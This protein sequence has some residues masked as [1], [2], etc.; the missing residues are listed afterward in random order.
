[1]VTSNLSNIAFHGYT[2]T[3]LQ[4]PHCN[5]TPFIF[6]FW[7]LCG[8]SPNFHIHV[9]VSDWSP[10]CI[11]LQK[12]WQTD[13]GNIEIENWEA[14]HYNYIL[15]IRRLHSFI[16]GNTYTGTRQLYWILTGPSFAVR[17]YNVGYWAYSAFWFL[18]KRTY[19]CKEGYH[20]RSTIEIQRI[21]RVSDS[22]PAFFLLIATTS[23]K[24]FLKVQKL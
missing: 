7:E 19:W 3:G 12:N 16:S 2:F 4:S 1:M 22:Y 6:L 20:L 5:K 11:W 13:P 18:R 23:N 21:L 14:E 17:V 10:Y 8:L 9:S 24:I 15:E